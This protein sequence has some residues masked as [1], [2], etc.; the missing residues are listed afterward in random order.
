LLGRFALLLVLGSG[1]LAAQAPKHD[2]P[3]WRGVA[4]HRYEVPN[5]ESASALAHELSRLLASSDPEL[6]DD[7]AYSILARWIGRPGIL[8]PDD[9]LALADKWMSNLKDGIGESGTNSVLKRSFSALCLSLIAERE[10]K[11]PFLG[12]SNY[13]QLVTAAVTY[14]QT[15][16]DLRGYDAKVGW[17]HATA[18][19]SD[20]LQALA[21]NALLKSEEESSILD[22]MAT[23]LASAPEVYTQ[24]EQDRMAQA[25]LALIRRADFAADSFETWLTRLEAEDK[26][27]WDVP[28]TPESLAHYQNHAY[29]LQAL[30]VRLDLEP[31]S[32][33]ITAVKRRVLG[34]LR[35]R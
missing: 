1:L 17:I 21:A 7:L 29:I 24:G 31:D 4:E 10:A 20:L 30:S 13:H 14:L 2:K 16:R 6:R 34:M 15:E 32:P 22:A 8:Q 27:V 23:R 18:H 35:N 11:T 3:F 5:G 9:L 33:K 12:T 28:L 25:V 26:K 19:T